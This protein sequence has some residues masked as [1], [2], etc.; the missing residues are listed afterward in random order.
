MTGRVA[1]D[2]FPGT[3]QDRLPSSVV[4]SHPRF[5]GPPGNSP[6]AAGLGL[7]GEIRK[8]VVGSVEKQQH[9]RSGCPGFRSETGRSC[10]PASREGFGKPTRTRFHLPVTASSLE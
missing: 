1:T 7:S 2:R 3:A 5:G 8:A 4:W 6:D 9:R 10:Q